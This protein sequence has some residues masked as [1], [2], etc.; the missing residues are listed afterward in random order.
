LVNRKQVVNT[1]L[2][3]QALKKMDI[4]LDLTSD[5]LRVVGLSKRGKEYILERFAIGPI[6]SSVFAAGK[7]AEPRELAARIGEIC[8]ANGIKPKR[9]MISLSGKAAIT[10]I[11]ELPKMGYAQTRQAIDLQINQY[12]PFPPGD[13][14]YQFKVL[15]PSAGSN[16]AMQ[17]VLLVATRRSTVDS[18]I[19]TLRFLQ[20]EPGGIKITSLAASKLILPRLEGYTQTAC[21]IDLRDTVTDLSFFVNN[22]FRLSRPIE[23]GYNSIIAK[24]SQA[25]SVSHADAEEHM[26]NDPV[27]LSLPEEEV[28][29]S[30]DNRMREALLPIFSNFISELIRSIR[31]Y[32][33]QAQRS[34]RVG[35]L[36][37][38][39]NV[40]LFKNL[41]RYIEQQT[42]LEVS[43]LSVQS[44]VT[45][46]QG[47]YSTELLREHAEKLVVA[48]GLAA[49]L[50]SK[51]KPELNLMPSTYYLKRRAMSV[52]GVGVMMLLAACI[53]YWYQLSLLDAKIGEKQNTLSQLQQEEGRYKGRADEF[54]RVKGEI[55]NN[56]PK[57]KQVFNLVKEQPIWPPL[58]AELG[59]VT[60]DTVFLNEI[61]F[62]S[63][64]WKIDVKGI[65]LSRWDLM[66]FCLSVDH[67]NLF[68]LGEV[69][70]DEGGSETGG[71]G[72]TGGGPRLGVGGGSVS[73]NDAQL[74]IDGKDL[75]NSGAVEASAPMDEFRP[76]RWTGRPG[77][78]IDDFFGAPPWERYAVA[79]GFEISL[80]VQAKGKQQDEAIKDLNTWEEVIQDVLNT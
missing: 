34:E 31:Y 5:E 63:S 24:V 22:N 49:D 45:T 69:S 48:A 26:K 38:Y 8:T 67:S 65:A 74:P 10:R 2:R 47:V 40:Q 7:V 71:G 11:V 50:V 27:D 12:V 57:F 51:V 3:K 54:D 17:E 56:I 16:P 20:I 19:Q 41:D 78:N 76:P 52:V 68:V 58:L 46:L 60:P 64:D 72:G 80:N 21:M 28:D 73:V 53:I 9:A 30:E 59:A 32:E 6:P 39:G 35:K 70:E 62:N 42:G 23:M 1:D 4:G 55:Q 36:F 61:T 33:S 25:L 79:W 18:L 13:T 14:I 15:P 44:L 75:L 43:I 29:E 37:I 77:H 66:L